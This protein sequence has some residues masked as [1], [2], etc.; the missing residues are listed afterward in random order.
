MGA[1]GVTAFGRSDVGR[2]RTG[3]EDAFLVAGTVFAVADG[4]GGHRAG[5]VASA[6]ALEPLTLL[7]GQHFED[8]GAA[9]A[10]LTAAA[11][12]ANAEVSRRSLDDPELE[13]MGTTLTALLIDNG[14]AHLV[15]VGDSR[16]YL[17]RGGAL[18]Q[19]TDD[20]TLV[21]A[22]IDQGRLTPA[23][24]GKHPHRSVIT[25][26]I[27]VAADVEVDARSITLEP[28]DTLL[29]C[30]DGLTGMI[31]DE[32]IA[33]LLATHAPADA[34]DALIAA[35]NEAGGADN[36]TVL[37]VRYAPERA[38]GAVPTHATE[39]IV[40]LAGPRT[41][42]IRTD[43]GPDERGDWATR[44]SDLGSP[45]KTPSRAASTARPGS[46]TRLL[47]NRFDRLFARVV[48]AVLSVAI[49]GGALALGAQLILDRAYLVG[50][51]DDEIVIYRGFDV[52]FGTVDL[53]RVHERPGLTL[54]EVP[55][56]L[57][58][59]YLDGRPAADLGDARRIVAGIPRVR[60]DSAGSAAP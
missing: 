29:L 40:P 34:I 55:P 2:I 3:N 19:L 17:S 52:Q 6:A 24:A 1:P 30:S 59:V 53:R 10:A 8:A 9:L 28:D 5:E 23:E 47:G 51:S 33:E 7:D 13:G 11:A 42:L 56:Y 15:H 39:V 48:V 50:V 37:I 25:R 49:A 32:R 14:A 58:Q 21:Q 57:H 54:G 44:Y 22:L 46:R 43:G 31:T 27:G 36:V 18:A 16:A 4:M 20:H 12:A 45:A 41:I 35:A 60:A 26:A 38:R